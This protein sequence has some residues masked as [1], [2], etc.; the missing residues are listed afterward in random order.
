MCAPKVREYSAEF[1]RPLIEAYAVERVLYVNTG[2]DFTTG[3]PENIVDITHQ[4]SRGI[5]ASDAGIQQSKI[6]NEPLVLSHL[7]G[8]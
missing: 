2:H 7:S 5:S 6:H 1:F 4:G 3:L 8:D